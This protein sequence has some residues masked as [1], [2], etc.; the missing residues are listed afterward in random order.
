MKMKKSEFKAMIKECIK[1]LIKEGA[2]NQALKENGLIGESVQANKSS[3]SV[4]SDSAKQ[5]HARA[6]AMRMA[7]ADDISDMMSPG[8]RIVDD[9]GL[10]SPSQGVLDPRMKQI[11]ESTAHG[12]ARGNKEEA[13]Q[14]AAIL[15]DTAV[16]T[17]PQQM[18]NDAGGGVA[19]MAQAGM[20]AHQE[21]VSQEDLE[22]LMGPHKD[23]NR[24]A[25]VAFSKQK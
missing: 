24:W 23:L 10:T 8:S 7:G 20:Q 3:A 4:I 2:F 15:A 5:A 16:N 21:S 9:S 22:Q 13:Q 12:I 1:E 18:M 6:I 19:A 25:T 14:L 11:I 17:Y